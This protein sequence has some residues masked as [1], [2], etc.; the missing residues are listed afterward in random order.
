MFAK[1]S[2]LLFFVLKIELLINIKVIVRFRGN[3]IMVMWE[4]EIGKEV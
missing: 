1:R 3:F 4:D 2:Y